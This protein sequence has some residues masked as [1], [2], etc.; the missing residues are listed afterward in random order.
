MAKRMLALVTVLA[1]LFAVAAPALAR[2]EAQYGGAGEAQYVSEEAPLEEGYAGTGVVERL[3]ER[4]DGTPVYGLSVSAEEGYYLEGD[5]DFAAFEGRN[6]YVAGEVVFYRGGGSFLR[7]E[8]MEPAGEGYVTGERTI[9][10]ED[11]VDFGAVAVEDGRT[12][13]AS[14]SFDGGEPSVA[15]PGGTAA[16][17]GAT[18]EATAT[19][20]SFG[21][22]GGGG[23][24]EKGGALGILPDSGGAPVFILGLGALLAAGGVLARRLER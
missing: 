11:I 24:F 16:D 6:V 12:L 14:Y 10:S 21:G 4:W 7:V 13:S 17:D 22:A 18:E 5:F 19:P 20:V 15:A 2:E 23:A 1:A 8:S 3:G 9:D